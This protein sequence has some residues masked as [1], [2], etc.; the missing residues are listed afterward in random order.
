MGETRFVLYQFSGNETFRRFTREGI[1]INRVIIM[2]LKEGDSKSPRINPLGM[3][4]R[5]RSI[6]RMHAEENQSKSNKIKLA[7]GYDLRITKS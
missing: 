5:L 6:I 3:H 4:F 1:K 7:F 2:S